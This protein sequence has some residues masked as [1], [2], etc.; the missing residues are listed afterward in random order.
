MTDKFGTCSS[1]QSTNEK[2]QTRNIIFSGGIGISVMVPSLQF[3]VTM[4]GSSFGK[5][6]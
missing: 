5:S 2:L 1:R 6:K 3:Q 4:D